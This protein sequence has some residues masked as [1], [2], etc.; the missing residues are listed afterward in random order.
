M[1][2]PGDEMATLTSG[3]GRLRASRAD[4]EQVVDVIKAAFVQDGLTRDELDTRVGLALAARTYADLAALTAD[5]PAEPSRAPAERSPAAAA[6][7]APV[8]ARP[9]NR[10]V[11]RAVKVGVGGI[12]FTAAAA[13]TAGLALGGPSAADIQTAFAMI[14]GA[15]FIIILGAAIGGVVA[16]LIASALKLLA[17]SR[18]RRRGRLAVGPAS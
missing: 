18:N 10:A 12:A 2:G 6:P 16:L 8:P 15:V 5:L 4:R 11:H 9:L 1:T 14:L 7:P 17:R 3:Y 13:T